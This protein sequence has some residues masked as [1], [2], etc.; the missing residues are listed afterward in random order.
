M[1]IV[2]VRQE[3]EIDLFIHFPETIYKAHENPCSPD[4][5]RALLRGEH[6]LSTDL[7]IQAYLLVDQGQIL[8][9]LAL[10]L[11]QHKRDAYFGFFETRAKAEDLKPLFNRVEEEAKAH[12]RD[13]ILGPVNGSFW[14]SYRMK[15]D[16]FDESPYFGEPLNQ[17]FYP[18][19]LRHLTYEPTMHYISNEYKRFAKQPKRMQDRLVDFKNREYEIRSPRRDET[20]TLLKTLHQLLSELYSDFPTYQAINLE[21]FLVLFQDLPKVLDLS[22]C[23]IAIYKDEVVGFLIAVPDYQLNLNSYSHPLKKLF[24]VLRKRRLKRAVLL[25]LGVLPEHLGL[26]LAMLASLSPTLDKK[27]MSLIGALIQKDKLTASYASGEI[28]QT[29]HYALWSKQL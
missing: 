15:M 24:F 27:K 20:N 21:Q 17:A 12:G 10:I 6:I 4:T 25:Y 14:L 18:E 1:K 29:R 7:N 26:G 3:A 11:P 23:K 2:L 28:T 13:Q 9:R 22:L 8:A 5:E 19:L 16:Q